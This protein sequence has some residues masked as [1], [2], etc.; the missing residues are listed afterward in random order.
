MLV[1]LLAWISEMR[2]L[3]EGLTLELQCIHHCH[4]AHS[5]SQPPKLYL[6]YFCSL[7]R[8][9]SG[10]KMNGNPILLIYWSFFTTAL[11]LSLEKLLFESI[12]SNAKTEK[13]QP[14]FTV[15]KEWNLK[16]YVKKNTPSLTQKIYWRE[17]VEKIEL[18]EISE[19]IPSIW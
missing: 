10:S 2:H 14:F 4:V 11:S 3:A 19:R 17:K 5:H 7:L 1:L 16:K 9:L 18:F 12:K 15:A 6:V 13:K 8:K